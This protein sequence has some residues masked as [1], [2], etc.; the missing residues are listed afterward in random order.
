MVRYR[1]ETRSLSDSKDVSESFEDALQ[2]QRALE[3][4]VRATWLALENEG[5]Q[6]PVTCLE[7]S[8]NL[9]NG[10]GGAVWFAG[11]REAQRIEDETGS[12][13]GY[14][15]WVSESQ[16]PLAFDPQVMSDFHAPSYFDPRGVIPV[17]HIRKVVAEYCQLAGG[18]PTCI[19]WVAGNQNGTRLA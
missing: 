9:K 11:G 7:V 6:A 19:E 16:E 8:I 14:Y 2:P 1:G 17:S 12:D 10:L 13:M 18:R 5:D 15:F 4:N 3:G